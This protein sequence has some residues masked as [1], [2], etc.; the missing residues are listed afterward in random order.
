M[1]SLCVPVQILR[2]SDHF[3]Q[4]LAWKKG[5]E[6]RACVCRGYRKE[7]GNSYLLFQSINQIRGERNRKMMSNSSLS[8]MARNWTQRAGRN[9][10]RPSELGMNWSHSPAG[11]VTDATLFTFLSTADVCANP[12]RP[13]AMINVT[14]QR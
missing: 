6:F 8:G 13:S 4:Y 1:C 3:H 2:A 7:G 11:V 14:N 10:P 9:L 5:R 12:D